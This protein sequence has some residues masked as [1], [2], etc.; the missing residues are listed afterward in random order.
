MQGAGKGSEDKGW[1]AVSKDQE[2]GI[3]LHDIPVG[4]SNEVVI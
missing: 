4:N 3:C 2:M 1:E